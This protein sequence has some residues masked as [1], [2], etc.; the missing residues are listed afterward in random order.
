MT[1]DPGVIGMIYHNWFDLPVQQVLITSL[2]F[3]VLPFFKSKQFPSAT[4]VMMKRFGF[5]GSKALL[6]IHLSFGVP[7]KGLVL[8]F[9]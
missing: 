8:I 7:A 6:I 5:L 2:S 4:L 1:L 9:H 3:A